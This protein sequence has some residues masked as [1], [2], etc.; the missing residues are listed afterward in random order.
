MARPHAQAV[1]GYYAAPQHLIPWVSRLIH[2]TGTDDL[3]LLDPCA[4]EGA[5]LAGL[6]AALGGKNRLEVYACELEQTR[7]NA[8]AEK[9]STEFGY[10]ATHFLHG[11]AFQVVAAARG[12]YG[13]HSGIHV[14]W[15]NPPYDH[16]LK[17]KRLEERWL[18]R[19]TPTLMP[20]G[21]L[22]FFVPYYALAASRLTLATHYRELHCFRVPDGDF[23]AFKQVLLVARRSPSVL[24]EADPNILAQ[25]DLWASDP[26]SMP[27]I[28]G[29]ESPVITV[30]TDSD[31]RCGLGQF[32]LAP[33]DVT[34]ILAQYR[35]WHASDRGG[36][37]Q[38][39]SG[40]FPDSGSLTRVYPLAVPPKPA[41]I[42]A[43]IA[44]G[45]FNGARI[46]P[47]DARSKLPALLVKGAFDREY[48]TVEERHDKQGNK[49]GEV[50]VQ[51]P[52]LVITALNLENQKFFTL[53]SSADLTNPTVAEDMTTAD[54]LAIY[55]RAL[56]RVML[57]QCPVLHDP[58]RPE[59]AIDLPPLARPLY[60][61][62]AEVTRAAVKLLGGL[63]C[64]SRRGKS[65]FVLG[66]IGSGKSSV[67]L[68]TAA[69]IQA[70]R[71]L[72]MCPPHLLDSWKDQVTAVTPWARTVV[73]SDVASMD[74]FIQAADAG[75]VIGILSRE[76]AK[77]GHAWATVGPTCPKCGSLVP[78]GDM[79]RTRGRCPAQRREARNSVAR[80]A[81]SVGL[82]L[83]YALPEHS[84]IRSLFSGRHMARVFDAASKSTKA[85][86]PGAFHGVLDVIGHTSEDERKAR[87]AILWAIGD[88]DLIAA[89]ARRIFESA[90]GFQ[91]WEQPA[92]RERGR[93]IMLLMGDA[94]KQERLA[95]ELQTAY[96][97][98]PSYWG[99]GPWASWRSHVDLIKGSNAHKIAVHKIT[100]ED[101]AIYYNGAARGTAA[102][103][104]LAL[105][106]IV[107]LGRF[108]L[109]RVCDEFL[110]QA[111]P[112][113]RRIALA[114]YL[115]RKAPQL[116]DLLILDEGHELASQESAQSQAA[117]RLSGLGIPT[118][119][120][121]GSIMGGYAESLFANQHALDPEFRREFRRDQR[122]DFVRR[123]GYL[124]Q[125]VS[126]KDVKTG[127]ITG[128]GAHS[129]RV[130]TT[131]RSLGNAPGVLPLFVLRY[132]LRIAVTLH[133][134]DLALDI[135]ARHD[136]A[137][138]VDPSPEQ[139][140][141][142]ARL[143]GSL[144]AQIKKDQFTDKA[145]KLWGQM[146]ELPSWLD[147]CTSDVGNTDAGNYVVAYPDGEVVAQ[148]QPVTDAVLPKERW[149]LERVRK[150]LDEGRNVMILAW[151][152]KLLPR[153][154]RLI[155]LELG[156][157]A[158]ILHSDKVPTGK[159]QGW[160]DREIIRKQRRIL[161]VNP[162]AVQTGLNNL[163]HFC[164][165]IWMENP[166]VNATVMRQTTGRVDRIGQTRETRIIFP[167]YRG[168]HQEKLHQLLLHKV[169]VGQAVDGLDAAAALE[170][171]GVG[172]TGFSS[173]SVG[174]Q[175]YELLIADGAL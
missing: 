67:A 1:A 140:K 82:K 171:A 39:I 139:L 23:E 107:R 40:L 159:R 165:Q 168:T 150:E 24:G 12:R 162:V 96:P 85:Y 172:E 135:P 115:A 99:G 69:A 42:A 61:A 143:Q 127:K 134:T 57:T 112:E 97:E 2:V 106:A 43:G 56:M 173:F 28:T 160:I 156:E 167:V 64:K 102:A 152:T 66:E 13:T 71:T 130:E 30:S 44:A 59:D 77:L 20:G 76:A 47:D 14:L 65:A 142:L 141:T 103:A 60:R 122:A 34:A 26:T 125:L 124:K 51:Q 15:A 48:A 109:T 33:L 4:G 151:H 11:D 84:T 16:D 46:E 136:V 45:V 132:L 144:A 174:R 91:T 19:F 73:L 50:Q 118:L 163:V 147:R 100:V 113:P 53:K 80:L 146:S 101:G 78:P 31:H 37:L 111:I 138:L 92:I 58:S 7:F 149:M 116:L 54:L 90:L 83:I 137:E 62:Q 108:G 21:A 164:S 74:D 110:Y 95:E 170:A 18:D 5:A 38:P 81:M 166:A 133:K 153:L 6:A 154:S 157:P 121:S 104:G 3:S 9:R 120:L 36:R 41:H 25:V 55:G 169:G 131:T 27:V 117:H 175:L 129:D 63:S 148:A 49:T 119:L 86:N 68:A 123:Y 88:D 8:L 114:P 158:P 10:A 93:Q 155:E 32:E 89:E 128:Y 22:L 161:V 52:K 35:P 98:E 70:K 145:G 29:T 105:D 72:I 126:E 79:A 75:P 87:A 17:F 94:L